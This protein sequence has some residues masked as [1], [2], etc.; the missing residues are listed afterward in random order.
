VGLAFENA[1]D[2]ILAGGSGPS[3]PSIFTAA[4]VLAEEDAVARLDVELANGA[5]FED[6]CCCPP[7]GRWP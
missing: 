1:E 5:V 6:L 3:S 2:V 7:R 4:R